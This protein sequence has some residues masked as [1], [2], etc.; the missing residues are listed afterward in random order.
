MID[1]LNEVVGEV[2]LAIE[3]DKATKK[4][5]DVDIVLGKLAPVTVTVGLGLVG[6]A[7][8]KIE[9]T[10][11]DEG[12]CK[13]KIIRNMRDAKGRARNQKRC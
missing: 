13:K 8:G 2:Q 4:E 5:L 12:R 7:G 10:V 9:V 11:A 3:H 6:T 1:M